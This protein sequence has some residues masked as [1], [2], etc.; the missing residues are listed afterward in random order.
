VGKAVASLAS[1]LGYRVIVND[2]RQELV[3]E[4]NIPEADRYLPGDI[5]Q[6]LE[7]VQ[8]HSNTHIT[9]LTRNVA[10]DR[11]ILPRLAETPAPYIGVIGSRRRWRETKRLL[12]DDGYTEADLKRFHSPIGL[13]L[14]AET[15]EE[16]AVSIM[17]EVIMLRRGG[18]GQRMKGGAEK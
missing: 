1:W 3:T 5:D 16:I 11:Q 9:I 8:I 4:E 10:L 7:Q 15:P 18:T 6:L 13:E 14:N 12:M 2:D 17:A